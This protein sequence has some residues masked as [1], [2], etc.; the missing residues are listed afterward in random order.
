[1]HNSFM[2]HR[3]RRFR[4]RFMKF[5]EQC[6]D[7]MRFVN[8]DHEVHEATVFRSPVSCC[9]G[10]AAPVRQAYDPF[11]LQLRARPQRSLRYYFNGD[12][13]FGYII[14]GLLHR[15][16]ELLLAKPDSEQEKSPYPSQH[17]PSGRSHQRQT[18]LKAGLITLAL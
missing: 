8:K 5:G 18:R 10:Y 14:V 13:A 11:A 2:D 7:D 9:G 12:E 16:K 15:S 1:M 4:E 3:D 6:L 17:R